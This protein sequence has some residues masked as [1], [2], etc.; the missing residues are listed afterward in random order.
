MA[1]TP[2][3]L[4]PLPAET[5][6]VSE[7]PTTLRD[8]SNGIESALNSFHGRIT[9]AE[10]VAAAAGP[11]AVAAVKPI[12]DQAETAMV[13][14]GIAKD[15]AVVAK[16]AAQAA[17]AD[18]ES[19]AAI[20]GAAVAPADLA[21]YSLNTLLS[22]GVWYQADPAKATAAQGYPVGAAGRLQIVKG[23]DAVGQMYTRQDGTRA[24]IR[25]YEAGSWGPW[26]EFSTPATIADKADKTYVD[27]QIDTRA[28]SAH[29]HSW[30]NITNPP[31]TYVPS[32]HGHAGTD[33]TS[34]T[35][36]AARLPASTQTASGTMSSTD[37]KKLDA[38]SSASTASTIMMTDS[39]GRF[40][41]NSPTSTAHVATKGYVDG[42]VA[43]LPTAMASGVRGIGTVSAGG[44]AVNQAVTFP[45]GR[46]NATPVVTVTGGHSRHSI[47]IQSVSTTGF[48][49]TCSNW[50]GNLADAS[51]IYWIAVQN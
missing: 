35:I 37:K 47:G 3:Y 49:F 2:N 45:S 9:T 46:F 34:G 36:N 4:L 39:N 10:G 17:K 12:K 20:A 24:Y 22:S 51:E 32:P 19:A 13:N 41:A 50:T 27:A 1:T 30:S 43:K 29:T 40:S 31:A 15:A 21:D 28:T 25:G 18:A 6:K 16:D 23:G 26:T 8:Q 33:I 7:T 11:S 38:A 5:L 48:T 42:Q 44:S 14:A